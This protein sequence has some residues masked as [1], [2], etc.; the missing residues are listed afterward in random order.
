MITII[1]HTPIEERDNELQWLH[2]QKIYPAVE[3]SYDWKTG[4][5]VT[6]FGV[7]VNKEQALTVKLRHKLD[8]QR[9]YRQR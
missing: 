8:S 3:D 4:K 6:R 2:E 9:D 7:I 5:E 1:Y